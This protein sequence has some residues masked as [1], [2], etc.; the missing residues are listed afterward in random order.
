MSDWHIPPTVRCPAI[1]EHRH[2]GGSMWIESCQKPPGHDG[3]HSAA[4]VQWGATTC[5]TLPLRGV[6]YT[7]GARL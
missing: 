1:R 5:S 3:E 7:S 2:S 6:Y 4:A